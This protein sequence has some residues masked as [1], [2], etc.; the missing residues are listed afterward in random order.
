MSQT[1]ME[2]DVQILVPLWLTD[3]RRNCWILCYPSLSKTHRGDL[4]HILTKA[5]LQKAKRISFISIT[6]KIQY[7]YFFQ[8]VFT[9]RLG[10]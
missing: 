5:S 9:E 1:I 10:K 3:I 4:E 6:W 7:G 8:L 2:I